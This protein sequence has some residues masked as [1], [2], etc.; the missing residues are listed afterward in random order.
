[1]TGAGPHVPAAQAK[2]HAGLVRYTPSHRSPNAA[3]L[4]AMH[5]LQPGVPGID[6]RVRRPPAEEIAVARQLPEEPYF[7]GRAPKKPT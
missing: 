5:C 3:R 6:E 1:M 4:A 2:R 7:H